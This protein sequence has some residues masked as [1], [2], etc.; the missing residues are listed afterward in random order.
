MIRVRTN[1]GR[2]RSEQKLRRNL[3]LI[4]SSAIRHSTF[5]PPLAIF[6]DE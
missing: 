4:R 6:A 5:L 3:L 1:Y 2:S